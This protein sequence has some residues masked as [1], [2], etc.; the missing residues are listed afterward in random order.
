MNILPGGSRALLMSPPVV[1]LVRRPEKQIQMNVN[2]TP[3]LV[4]V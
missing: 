2:A 4:D 1:R 3:H